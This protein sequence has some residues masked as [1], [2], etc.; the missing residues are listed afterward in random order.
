VA[1]SITT[2]EQ[3]QQNRGCYFAMHAMLSKGFPFSQL[4]TP[5]KS[6]SKMMILV[7]IAGEACV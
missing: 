6:H 7:Q 4:K 3:F 2:D 5:Y 1:S